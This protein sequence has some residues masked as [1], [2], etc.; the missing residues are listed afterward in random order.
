MPVT[1]EMSESSSIHSAKLVSL[2][3]SLS[4]LGLDAANGGLINPPNHHEPPLPVWSSLKANT[5][6][7]CLVSSCSNMSALSLITSVSSLS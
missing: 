6:I 4:G 1:T 2:A 3:R 7:L 5:H